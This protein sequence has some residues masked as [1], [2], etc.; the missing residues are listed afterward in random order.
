MGTETRIRNNRTDAFR[1]SSE[2][3]S[4]MRPQMRFQPGEAVRFLHHQE[5]ED[6]HLSNGRID[7]IRRTVPDRAV[8][9]IA[10]IR[11]RA[12]SNSGH[13]V[14]NLVPYVPH[15]DRSAGA[16]NL[17]GDEYAVRAEGWKHLINGE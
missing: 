17:A 7:C 5:L 11:Q 14:L 15:V 16:F 13:P 9:V 3:A 6:R 8:R 1:H 4:L 10:S 2:H 12:R